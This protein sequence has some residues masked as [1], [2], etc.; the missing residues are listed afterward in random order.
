M[1]LV[2]MIV[3]TFSLRLIY[4][5]LELQLYCISCQQI[6]CGAVHEIL[7]LN[8]L[9]YYA[10]PMP[11]TKTRETKKTFYL[12]S[13]KIDIDILFFYRLGF[14]VLSYAATTQRIIVVGICNYFLSQ[15]KWLFF[16]QIKTI[17]VYSVPNLVIM[18]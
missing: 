12:F 6:S 3:Q 17:H 7:N 15:Q 14:F 4:F 1:Q 5:F 11:D 18:I 16:F 9:L 13:V 2:S 8:I 10:H